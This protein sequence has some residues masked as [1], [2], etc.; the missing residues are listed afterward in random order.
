MATR[1]KSRA[2]PVSGSSIAENDVVKRR[3]GKL[4]GRVC[5]ILDITCCVK[6]EEIGCRRVALDSLVL[7][8]G[9]PP[10]CDPE[11]TTCG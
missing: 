11:C 2:V 3:T 5:K 7:A 4:I 10:D 6:F 1:T 8:E 9:N